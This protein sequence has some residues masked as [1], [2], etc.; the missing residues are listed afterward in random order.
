MQFGD[1]S[2]YVLYSDLLFNAYGGA[3]ALSPDGLHLLFTRE[4]ARWWQK[5]YVGSQASQVW[6]YDIKQKSFRKLSTGDRG[7]R[8][9]LWAGGKRAYIVS[10]QDGTK[11]L[12][13][14]DVANGRRRQLTRFKDDGVHFPSISRDRSTIVFHVLFDLYRY[15]VKRG[16]QPVRLTLTRS[17]DSAQEVVR[18]DQVGRA[19]QAA[20]SDDGREIAFIA[21]G[22]VW[23]MDTELKE[24][25]QMT[26]SPEE[27]R[28]P[29]FSPDHN[30]IVFVSERDGQCDLWKA[31]RVD[32]KKYWWQNSEFE[33]HR[34][35]NDEEPEYGPRFV[36]DGRIAFTN[37]RGDLWTMLADG[38]DAFKLLSSW[39]RPSYSFSPDGK[40][41]A[42]AIDDDDFNRDI[43][44]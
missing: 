2:S 21:G 11:N 12:W 20:F 30:S 29:V 16:G 32:E 4:G 37:L 19:T 40:W 43:W 34:L 22:D 25:V 15:D 35:T 38:D 28:D 3:G 13:A 9:P 39:N 27:E 5:Q 26:F 14:L 17:G 44:L 1:W 41:L 31:S 33:F 42:Y 8:W 7:E 24:P 18:H 23:V 10:E 6:H 36:A